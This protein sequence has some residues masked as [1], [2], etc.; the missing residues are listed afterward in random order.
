MTMVEIFRTVVRLREHN[1]TMDIPDRS[2]LKAGETQ[3]TTLAS[4]PFGLPLSI[5]ADE[6][7]PGGN[8][9]FAILLPNRNQTATQPIK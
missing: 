8:P 9:G 2:G 6:K 1:D 3:T 5:P 7:K 4:P